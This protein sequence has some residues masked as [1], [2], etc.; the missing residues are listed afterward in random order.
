M[1]INS[2]DNNHHRAI[3]ITT[4]KECRRAVDGQSVAVCVCRVI[5]ATMVVVAGQVDLEE[6]VILVAT[7]NPEDLVPPALLYAS[8]QHSSHILATKPYTLCLEK[9]PAFLISQGNVATCLR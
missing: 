8:F 4:W 1:R 2:A 9:V 6:M 5:E 3:A 7:E